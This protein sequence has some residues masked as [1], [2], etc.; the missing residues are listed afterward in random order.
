M[1]IPYRRPGSGKQETEPEGGTPGM[2]HWHGMPHH[3]STII[4]LLI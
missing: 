3:K 2:G 4:F 1:A